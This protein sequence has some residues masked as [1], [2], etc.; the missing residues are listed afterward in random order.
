MHINSK[1]ITGQPR[2][3]INEVFSLAWNW[4][5]R[6]ATPE[7]LMAA[8]PSLD[9][10]DLHLWQDYWQV[11]DRP[12]G[13]GSLVYEEGEHVRLIASRELYSAMLALIY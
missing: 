10:L 9:H 1:V 7:A 3:L 11:F 12:E 13:E 6:A 8:S 5:D 2:L 4:A